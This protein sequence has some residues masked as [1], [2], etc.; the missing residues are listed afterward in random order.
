MQVAW[1]TSVRVGVPSAFLL[2]MWSICKYSRSTSVFPPMQYGYG[3]RMEKLVHSLN[4]WGCDLYLGHIVLP[5]SCR[6]DLIEMF[7][8]NA[9][10]I[11]WV[12]WSTEYISRRQRNCLCFPTLC[13]PVISWKCDMLPRKWKKQTARTLTW[14]LVAVTLWSAAIRSRLVSDLHRKKACCHLINLDDM[15][16]NS[17]LSSSH[18]NMPLLMS[19]FCP[20]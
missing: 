8:Y 1:H 18:L 14:I 19:F 12:W 3:S 2:T 13:L 5:S 6:K 10:Y 7:F 4:N 16:Q 17:W 9:V 11:W 20:L 15:K